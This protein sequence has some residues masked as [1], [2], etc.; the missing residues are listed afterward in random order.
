MSATLWTYP[1]WWDIVYT[2]LSYDHAEKQTCTGVYSNATVLEFF[3]DITVGINS[4]YTGLY[5]YFLADTA[6]SH[7]CEFVYWGFSDLV[8]YHYDAYSYAMWPN[9]C[10][11]ADALWYKILEPSGPSV[12]ERVYNDSVTQN[13]EEEP[14]EAEAETD[15]ASENPGGFF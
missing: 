8:N 10:Q 3:L 14:I 11:S 13:N 7:T 9:N 4:C 2:E 5:D 6:S 15:P 12:T 1:L